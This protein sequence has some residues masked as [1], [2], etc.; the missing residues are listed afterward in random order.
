MPIRFPDPPSA[1]TGAALD[2]MRK[3][4]DTLRNMPSWSYGSVTTPNSLITGIK[5]DFFVNLGSASTWSRVW[6]KT[7]PDDGSASTVSWV[8][9][10]IA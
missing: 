2:Y 1:F 6:T 10:R 8:V 4:A 3:V 5:G 7:G 9:V